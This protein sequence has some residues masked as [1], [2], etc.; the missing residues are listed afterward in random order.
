MLISKLL[1]VQR[2]VQPQSWCNIDMEFGLSWRLNVGVVR[3]ITIICKSLLISTY[4]NLFDK[5]YW[6]VYFMAAFFA[7][8]FTGFRCLNTC[9]DLLVFLH[10]LRS[11]GFPLLPILFRLLFSFAGWFFSACCM[12]SVRRIG[13]VLELTFVN[14]LTSRET[15]ESFLSLSS[16]VRLL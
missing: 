8:H 9:T 12:S 7:R 10:L 15:A 4:L 6:L 13:S 3:L 2:Q 5:L 14:S 11:L 16:Q 1:H